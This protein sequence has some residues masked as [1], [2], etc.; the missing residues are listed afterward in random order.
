MALPSV[1][2]ATSASAT[3]HAPTMAAG[4][5]RMPMETK[6]NDAN[7]SRSGTISPR[8]L[9]VRSESAR[10]SPATKA[11]S[12]TLTPSAWAAKAVP[13]AM[14]ATLMT[15]SSRDR[16]WATMASSRGSSREPAKTTTATKAIATVTPVATD[17]GDA[18]DGA[19][20]AVRRT[21]SRIVTRSCTIDTPMAVRP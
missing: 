13:M 12:A 2:I 4:S 16:S 14:T 1:M 11:P 6:K 18:S 9:A 21:T 7:S 19:T 17:S 20:L 10:A 8:T 5:S 3:G 15:N